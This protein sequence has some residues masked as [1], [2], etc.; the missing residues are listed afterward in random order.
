MR[1]AIDARELHGQPTGVGRFLRELLAAWATMPE[2]SAHEFMPLA[3]NGPSARGGTLWEQM[4]L[5]SLARDAGADVLFA[6]AYSGP[7]LPPV[8]MV[9]AIHDVSYAAH[10]EWFGWREGARRRTLVQLAARAAARVVTISEFSKREIVAHLGIDESKVAVAYPGVTPFTTG[11]ALEGASDGNGVLFVGSIFDRRHVPEM[12]EGFARLARTSPDVRL[13]I[14][15]DNRTS[16][17]LRL[18]SIAR[19]TGVGDRI[20]LRSYVPDEELR[21][22]YAT[23][24]A[25]VFLSEYEGF[26]LTPLEALAAGVPGLLLDT[27]VAREVCGDAA[28]YVRRADPV[29]VERG[30]RALLFDAG[31][32]QR[33]L[34]AAAAVLARYSWTDCARRVLGVLLEAAI[35]GDKGSAPL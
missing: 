11:T 2:A 1:I 5:P 7:I 28:R 10:P 31:E 33:I 22:L 16:P 25:F 24:A 19:A 3:P 17:P 21:S 15:G 29:L 12:I 23:S 27:P 30:L 14:V 20:L 26:G 13:A 6:P 9:V 35:R 34:D 4:V 32:R 8:P 18:E